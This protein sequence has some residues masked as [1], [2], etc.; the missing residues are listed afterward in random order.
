MNQDPLPEP[1]CHC[2]DMNRANCK[3]PTFCNGPAVLDSA[4]CEA[5]TV[6]LCHRDQRGGI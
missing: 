6:D 5:C 1:D 4:F 2:K 3:V